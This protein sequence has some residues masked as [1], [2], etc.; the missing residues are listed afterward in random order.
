MHLT[1]S[2]FGHEW[3]DLDLG[4]GPRYLLVDGDDLDDDIPSVIH[5]DSLATHI[6]PEV[7]DYAVETVS[8]K[9][10]GFGFTLPD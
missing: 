4:R 2:F 8:R 10:A 1:I 3:M 7:D 9:P 6:D 5:N